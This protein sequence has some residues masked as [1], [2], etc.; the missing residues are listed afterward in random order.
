MARRSTLAALALTLVVGV[1][2]PVAAQDSGDGTIPP[3][4]LRLTTPLLSARR[5]PELLTSHIAD[6]RLTTAVQGVL[7]E[8]PDTTC[9]VVSDAGRRIVE[10][11]PEL[12]LAPASTEKLLTAT[13]V[14]DTIPLDERLV[15]TV[16]AE[17]TPDDGVLDGDLWIVGG[18]DPLLTTTGYTVAFDNPAQVWHD[19]AQLADRIEQSGITEI[20]GSVIGDDSRY[21]TERWVSTWPTRHQRQGFV[22]PLSALTVNDGNTGY[23]DSPD[24]LSGTRLPGDPPLLA[25]ETLVTLLEDRGIT[26]EGEAGTGRA[27][28]GAQQVASLESLPVRDLVGEMLA[29]SDNTTAELLVKELGRR[30]GGGGTTAAGTQAIGA[31]L[32]ARGLPLDGVVTND[33]SGLDEGNRVTC[34]LLAELLDQHGPDSVLAGGLAVAGEKGTLRKRLLD[35]PVEGRVVAKTGTLNTV[36]ALA[37]WVETASGKDLTFAFLVNGENPAGTTT[38]DDLVTVLYDYPQAPTADQLDPEPPAPT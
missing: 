20:R 14:L 16:V 2:A 23:A 6:T 24:A 3:S 28:E 19:Y 26:V 8:S 33:G 37:G 35:T 31:A 18:G 22:G 25:A 29:E 4:P 21:D 34:D 32:A 11:N 12:P 36:W 9:L 1:A 38:Q 27:P 30:A 13:A 10:E 5:V 7:E 17:D 15:T